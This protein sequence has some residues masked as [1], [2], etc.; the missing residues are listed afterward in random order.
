MTMKIELIG[1]DFAINCNHKLDIFKEVVNNSNAD[2]ILFPGHTLRDEEDLNYLSMHLEN[3]KPIVIFELEEADPTGCMHTN[4]ELYIYKNGVFED[5]YTSQIFATA[6]D[7][8]GNDVLMGKFFDELPRRTIT[9]CG[10]RI[11]ILQC[12]ETALL[13]SHKK[14]NYKSRFRFRDNETLHQRYLDMLAS[15][16]IFLNPIHDLQGEQGI[17]K[18]RRIALSGDN[19]YYMSTSALNRE[20]LGNFKSKRLQYI[21]HNEEDIDIKPYINEDMGYVIRTIYID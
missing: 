6:D 10:K 9:C 14:D 13:A 3:G 15:T 1:F 8:N 12:G 16:D 7:I 4:N 5:M 19:R 20:M 18:Q 11:T 21:L 2:L 17:M